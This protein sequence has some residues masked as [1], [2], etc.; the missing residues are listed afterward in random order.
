MRERT[1]SSY[2]ARYMG[3]WA[4]YTGVNKIREMELLLNC[5]LNLLINMG[6]GT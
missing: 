6:Q 4:G 5:V 1:R 3:F 2:G